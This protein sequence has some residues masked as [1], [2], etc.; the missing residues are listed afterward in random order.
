M[1]QAGY[2]NYLTGE[3]PKVSQHPLP[4]RI[5]ERVA[6]L[7]ELDLIHCLVYG[8]RSNAGIAAKLGLNESTV[9]FY[10]TKLYI[11]FNL[12]RFTV[13]SYVYRDHQRVQACKLNTWI[14]THESELAPTALEEL[15][16]I[17]ASQVL[18]YL[19]EEETE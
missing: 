11:K 2:F 13:S 18:D 4:A 6:T 10:L 14:R 5:N 15:K 19:R 12:N 1:S 3:Y 9:K 17:L 7:R 8:P 16:Q